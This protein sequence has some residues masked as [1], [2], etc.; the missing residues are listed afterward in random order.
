MKNAPLCRGEKVFHS[1]EKF[2]TLW[3]TSTGKGGV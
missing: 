1:V 3:K 2:S